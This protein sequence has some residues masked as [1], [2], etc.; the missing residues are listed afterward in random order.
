MEKLKVTNRVY[1]L[2]INHEGI[3]FEVIV[4]KSLYGSFIEAIRIQ[5]KN[6]WR[7]IKYPLKK[8]MLEEVQDIATN[9]I[10]INLRDRAIRWE[11]DIA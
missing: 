10:R 6:E 3:L 7:D 9:W 5:S 1:T 11:S 4:E 2:E 8:Q